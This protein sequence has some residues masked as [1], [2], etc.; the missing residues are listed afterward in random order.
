MTSRPTGS[1]TPSER[2][3]GFEELSAAEAGYTK[4]RAQE[5]CQTVIET[6]EAEVVEWEQ[7]TKE[8]DSRW[9]EAKVDAAVIQGEER[10]LSIQ[11]DITEQ[12]RRERAIQAL[13][14]ATE[15]L[16]TAT[17]LED[18]ATIAVETASD[19]L[20]L[21]MAVCWFHDDETGRLQPAAATD[22]VHEAGLVSGLSADRYEYDVFRDG[23]VT[24][25]TP[26]EH[27]ADNPL[28][29]GV[30]L[31]LADHGLI[32]A[33]TRQDT[34][35]DSTVLDVIKALADHITTALD[36]V[37]RDQEVRESE[38]RFRLI[39]ERIDEVI[40]LAEPDFSEVLYV[41]PAYEEI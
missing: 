25:Y 40:Y 12:K 3:K 23:D 14:D 34:D 35:A 29:T 13:Q 38:R 33:A 37:D 1:A 27:A 31:P 41:N 2:D 30:L 17:T 5:L 26:G 16:Q 39:A 4:E 9:I 28:E 10:I 7:K 20:G 18:I 36:R 6:G 11:R 15:R 22:P 8:G 21:P 32:V 24:E 19:A